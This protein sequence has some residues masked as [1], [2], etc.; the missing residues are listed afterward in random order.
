MIYISHND[1]LSLE[2]PFGKTIEWIEESFLM[3]KNAIS[4][5]ARLPF[6][7]KNDHFMN[8][9]PCIVQFM[10]IMGVKIVTR[11]PE[12]IPSIDGH[13][14]LYD[15]S[16]GELKAILDAFWIT[17]VR[18]GAAAALSVKYLLRISNSKSPI[19]SIMGLGNVGM[20]VLECLFDIYKDTHIILKIL[21]YKN[22]EIAVKERFAK[23]DV[24]FIGIS[25]MKDFCCDSDV[26]ISCITY[27]DRLLAEPEWF[28]P[29]ALLLPV[30]QRGFENC[31]P[32]FNRV[33]VADIEQARHYKYFSQFHNLVELTDIIND[34]H[35]IVTISD[36]ERI[37]CYNMGLPIHD[38][39]FSNHIYNIIKQEKKGIAIIEKTNNKSI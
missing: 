18:T 30:H 11:Y 22:H 32:L 4:V 36:S 35:H 24:E 15:L 23:K 17:A 31:D 37:L 20:S 6:G 33:V 13:I 29:G 39:I 5:H 26:V 25:N 2:I 12:R 7:E 1:I 9:M 27:A 38:I 21:K 10:N 3:K 19:I 8:T 14:L 16:T 34:K 28:K